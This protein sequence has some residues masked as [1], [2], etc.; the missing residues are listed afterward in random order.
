MSKLK[1]FF[2][3]C[4]GAEP[5]ILDDPRCLVERSKYAAIGAT[6]LST[7]VLASLSGGYAMYTTFQSA[8][9]AIAFGIVWGLII[10]NLDR[11]IV[12][13]IKRQRINPDVARKEQFRIRLREFG[14]AVPRFL[15]AILISLVITRPIELKLFDREI[16]AYVEDEK[17]K[18]T[19]EMQQQKAREFP[20]I[21]ELT[22]ANEALRSELRTKEI[23]C[24][25]KYEL[26]MDEAMGTE[27]TGQSGAHTSRIKGKGPLY[28]ERW[29]N[30]ENCRS[31]LVQLRGQIE[32]KIAANDRQ[33]KDL[34]SQRDAA[35]AANK[36]KIDAMDGLLMRLKGHSVLTNENVS[37]AL[38][39][40]LLVGLFILLETAPMVVKLLSKRGPY[41]DICEAQEYEVLRSQQRKMTE[42]DDEMETLLA[43]KRRRDA[44]LLDADLK[45]R[46]SVIVSM[47]TNAREKL[48][49][50]RREVPIDLVEHWKTAE[51]NNFKSRFEPESNNGHKNAT[52]IAS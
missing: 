31:D 44:A 9:K 25:N 34:E 1:R 42:V 16:N 21:G 35:V 39:S 33:I 38:A 37:L 28:E 15:L 49:D 46:K 4:S 3:L 17:S 13:S 29:Q 30:S 50:I 26:A 20:R 45:L 22:V 19:V 41:E 43:L 47:E 11:Y 51:L 18:K 7:A 14:S 2:I 36:A 5:S 48:Q 27:A 10:F 12:S 52:T 6:V 8:P 32:Q 24:T 23:E 40:L